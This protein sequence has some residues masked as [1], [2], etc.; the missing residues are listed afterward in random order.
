MLPLLCIMNKLTEKAVAL[1]ESP[2]IRPATVLAIRRWQPE[3]LLEVDLHLPDCDMSKWNSAQHIKCKVGLL[4]YRDYTPS[5]WDAGT[6]TCTILVHA[7]HEGPGSRWVKSLKPGDII[8]YRGI[9]SSHQQP[10]AGKRLLFLGDETTIGHFLAL[11]Q[12]AASCTAVSGA[13]LLAEP[14][15]CSEFGQ[16]FTG[17]DLQALQKRAAGDYTALAKWVEEL[18]PAEHSETVFYLAGH[19]PTVVHLQKLLRQKGFSSGQ[20]KAQGFWD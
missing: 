5:G 6:R 15:H 12:L 13:I 16:Y 7:A 8:S 2:F 9:G 11:R 10:V 17:W 14:H 4:A 20:V 1:V 3:S 19:I 18:V